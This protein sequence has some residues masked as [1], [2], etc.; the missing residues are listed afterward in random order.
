MPARRPALRTML[1]LA[2]ALA[3]DSASLSLE[4]MARLG[5]SRTEARGQRD[6]PE[7]LTHLNGNIEI[8][9]DSLATD[10]HYCEVDAA[11]LADVIDQ[12]S[13]DIALYKAQAASA[14][15]DHIR[16]QSAIKSLQTTNASLGLELAETNRSCGEQTGSLTESLQAMDF[17]AEV[18]AGIIRKI[19]DDYK[20][21]LL[22][23]GA[24]LAEGFHSQ[25][26]RD[27]VSE[28]VGRW[29]ETQNPRRGGRLAAA[30][31]YSAAELQGNML[32]QFE[33]VALELAADIERFA[34]HRTELGSKCSLE[35]ASLEAQAADLAAR[36]ERWGTALAEAAAR[37]ASASEGQG[38]QRGKLSQLQ[39]VNTSNARACADR[40]TKLD[41]RLRHLRELRGDLGGHS[42][43]PRSLV[44]C[45][46]GAWTAGTCSKTCL[47]TDSEEK[48]T[49]TF[50]RQVEV[51]A[52][53]L[54]AGCGVMT[55]TAHCGTRRCKINCDQAEWSEWSAC[56]KNCGG[57]ARERLR[58]T[59]SEARFGGRPCGPAS[60]TETCNLEHCSKECVL[61]AWSVVSNEQ[62]SKECGGGTKM[63]IRAVL[64]PSQ[65]S[66]SCPVPASP[67]RMITVNCNNFPCPS[68][69]IEPA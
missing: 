22:R 8:T 55:L 23:D 47:E 29:R 42:R 57:G 66:G 3:P 10:E 69:I 17:D 48:G 51:E 31:G 56:S 26:L 6:I 7:L 52:T 2:A 19:K 41:A 35:T 20:G 11:N 38:S 25:R 37:N 34:A 13:S 21:F 39:T 40:R 65:A 5:A 16:A 32:V 27:L 54:G 12:T 1:A 36:L 62:C 64:V 68:R 53:N 50:Q 46:P 58:E 67:E 59:L 28:A 14:I 43:G 15:G 18:L 45:K 60:E 30:P 33:E 24:R 44:D 4:R 61:G 63:A 49:K 9:Q